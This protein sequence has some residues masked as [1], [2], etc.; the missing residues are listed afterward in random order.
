M[1]TLD[2]HNTRHCDVEEKISRF[3]NWAE[4]PCRIIT[5]NSD[6]MKK[7]TKKILKRYDLACYNENDYNHGSYIV[8]D[9]EHIVKGS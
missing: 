9:I 4:V 7:I 5:G 1:K 3:L 8:V 6:R 2:L